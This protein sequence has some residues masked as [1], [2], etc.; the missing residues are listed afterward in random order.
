MTHVAGLKNQFGFDNVVVSKQF[1]ASI[2]YLKN[3]V[4]ENGCIL[5]GDSDGYRFSWPRDTSI[6]SMC[7]DNVGQLNDDK[8]LHNLSEKICYGLRDTQGHE[9]WWH[10]RYWPDGTVG[11]NWADIQKDETALAIIAITGHYKHIEDSAFLN[12]MWGTVQNAADFLMGAGPS[13]DLWEEVL[14][15]GH[16]FTTQSIIRALREASYFAEINNWADNIDK[17]KSY[18]AEA[19]RL[20][21]GLGIFI[22]GD[23]ISC[24]VGKQ[25][26]TLSYGKVNI[27]SSIIG[28]HVLFDGKFIKNPLLAKTS[29][30]LVQE[31]C[32]QFSINCG[33]DTIGVMRYIGDDYDG[34]EKG[35]QG[36]PWNITTLWMAQKEYMS[37]YLYEGD[38]YFGWVVQHMPKDGTLPEQVQR[39]TGKPH[40]ELNLM[41]SHAEYINTCWMRDKL[42]KD[43]NGMYYD[44]VDN[45]NR[46]TLYPI[47]T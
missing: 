8:C 25:L 39:V 10:Q 1:K 5:A 47:N 14:C 9:G 13:F 22:E 21:R 11:P 23:T 3:S 27:D 7:L 33:S 31:S 42:L 46:N 29:L 26:Q 6:I 32:G 12:D 34:F 30:V 4:P 2:D 24:S 44:L 15:D 41:W 17:I 35:S 45:D 28:A 43:I 19:S 36:N 18:R 16:Y 38:K 40:G 37:G 20:E